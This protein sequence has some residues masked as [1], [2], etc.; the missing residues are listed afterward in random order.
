MTTGRSQPGLGRLASPPLVPPAR[1]PAHVTQP[2][3]ANAEDVAWFAAGGPGMSDSL[4]RQELAALTAGICKALNDRTRLVLLYALQRRPHS[5]KE[6]CEV[7]QARRRPPHRTWL[8]CEAGAW[9]SQSGRGT[10]SSTP[11]GTRR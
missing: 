9:L 8:S 2:L 11:C 1:L 10:A 5:V 4:L 6:L 7:I 3:D